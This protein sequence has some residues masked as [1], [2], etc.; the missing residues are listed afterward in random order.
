MDHHQKLT[1]KHQILSVGCFAYSFPDSRWCRAIVRS[2]KPKN[3]NSEATK[4]TQNRPTR[5]NQ[6]FQTLP[7]VSLIQT[8]A[9]PCVKR[10]VASPWWDQMTKSLWW[11]QACCEV[12]VP[13]MFYVCHWWHTTHFKVLPVCPELQKQQLPKCMRAG[14][15]LPS[16]VAR[17][18]CYLPPALAPCMQIS[19]NAAPSRLAPALE[20]VQERVKLVKEGKKMGVEIEEEM[21]ACV[22]MESSKREVWLAE[23]KRRKTRN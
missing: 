6:D 5:T 4:K 8:L 11:W 17:S 22:W 12:D 13:K 9:P 16:R 14:L 19:I 18:C 7:F 3:S 21:D 10:S 1:L 15:Q 20:Q 2:R 23:W